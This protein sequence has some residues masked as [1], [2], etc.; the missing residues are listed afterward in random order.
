[1][2]LVVSHD[3]G[4]AHVLSSWV[5]K[6]PQYRYSFILDGPAISIFKGKLDNLSNL[7]ISSLDDCLKKTH[8]TIT[9][10]S[11]DSDIEN[12]AICKSKERRVPVITFIDHWVNYHRRFEL[13]GQIT[14]PNVI[15]V[16]DE[17]ALAIARECFPLQKVRL[18]KNPYFQEVRDEMDSFRVPRHP[19]GKIRILYVTDPIADFCLNQ[20]G[21]R[22]HWEYTEFDAL[23]LFLRKVPDLCSLE[24]ID[25]VRLRYHPSEPEGKYQHITDE[26][27]GLPVEGSPSTHLIEDCQ[28]SDWVVGCESMALVVGLL[29]KKRVI[30]CIPA[31]GKA[32][33]LP[34]K[35]IEKIH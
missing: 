5:R 17:D 12:I 10:I 27:P 28:W 18:V 3:A 11:W 25:V 34:Q 23:R 21:N 30:S 6:H 9:S 4:G 8:F 7:S 31:H 26:F 33:S 1:M 29:A 14:L 24:N 16:G 22:L 15:W 2:V 19:E 35:D 13:N 32:C 20:F